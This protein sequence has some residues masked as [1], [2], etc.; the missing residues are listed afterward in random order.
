MKFPGEPQPTAYTEATAGGEGGVGVYR[1]LTHGTTVSWAAGMDP[2]NHVGSFTLKFTS[3]SNTD[4]VP[5]GK[6]YT[7]AGTLDAR[8]RGTGWVGERVYT[9]YTRRAA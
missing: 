8:P 3:V 6:G 2:T 1:Y 4:T 7:F 9:V 5:G